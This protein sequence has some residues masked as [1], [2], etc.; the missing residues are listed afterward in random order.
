MVRITMM[1]KMTAVIPRS[2]IIPKSNT[3]VRTIIV[4]MV[5]PAIRSVD[6]KR[7]YRQLLTRFKIL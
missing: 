5:A 6:F 4:K 7:M 2:S 3:T 1:M